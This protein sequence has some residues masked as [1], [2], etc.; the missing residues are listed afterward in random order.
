MPIK[1]LIMQK[2]NDI[3][4]DYYVEEEIE[5]YIEVTSSKA[6]KNKKLRARRKIEEMRENKLLQRQIDSYCYD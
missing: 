2:T 5:L 6:S 3:F 1:E 4:S